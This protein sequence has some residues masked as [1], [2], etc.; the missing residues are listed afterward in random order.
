MGT[1]NLSGIKS[2]NFLLTLFLLPGRIIQWF[3]YIFVANKNY[4][5]VRQQSRLARSPIMTYLYSIFSWIIILYFLSTY[6]GFL[7]EFL[8][9]FVNPF[10]WVPACKVIALFGPEDFSIIDCYNLFNE[11]ILE[12]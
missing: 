4:G 11:S 1:D 2:K 8:K 6:L 3:L 7:D 9:Y 10:I 5:L 12:N